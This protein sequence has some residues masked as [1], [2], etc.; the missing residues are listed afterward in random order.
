MRHRRGQEGT[1]QHEVVLLDAGALATIL[2]T[3]RRHVYAARSRG[4]IPAGVRVPG[5]GLR[6]HSNLVYEWVA[7]LRGEEKKP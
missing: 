6:W 5:L 2:G 4:Q 1:A 3:T 7:G